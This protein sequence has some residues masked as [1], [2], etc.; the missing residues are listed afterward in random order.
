MMLL[1]TQLPRDDVNCRL[2]EG[3]RC[4]VKDLGH[5]EGMS[6]TVGLVAVFAMCVSS[7]FAGVYFE[8]ILKTSVQSLWAKNVQM[9]VCCS[10]PSPNCSS[11]YTELYRVRGMYITEQCHKIC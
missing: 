5:R 7:G 10:L 11:F 2:E 4:D 8:K 1:F 9:G 3:M 6:A